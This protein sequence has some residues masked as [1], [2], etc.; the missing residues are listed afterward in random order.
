MAAGF[1]SPERSRGAV[2]CLSPP[3][4]GSWDP[5][6]AG[7]RTFYSPCGFLQDFSGHWCL[8]MGEE[9]FFFF[10][11]SSG[12]QL[13]LSPKV[14]SRLEGVRDRP[15]PVAVNSLQDLPLSPT[16]PVQLF[17]NLR[18]LIGMTR[19]ASIAKVNSSNVRPW[20]QAFL[21]TITPQRLIQC[22]ERGRTP[23]FNVL[24]K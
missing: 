15:C 9:V 20:E 21:S 23:R 6:P 14:V 24:I 5:N 2:P 11:F 12:C 7:T 1:C 8:K 18:S 17:L 22:T 13:S 10:F 4:A 16:F 19:F 3:L